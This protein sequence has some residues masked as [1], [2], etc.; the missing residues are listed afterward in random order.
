MRCAACISPVVVML[1]LVA[2]SVHSQAPK[3]TVVFSREHIRIAV[4]PDGIRVDASYVFTNRSAVPQRQ[5]LF[6]PFPIDSLHPYPDAVAVRSDGKEVE[7][8][9]Q[10]DGVVITID[11]P[12]RGQSVLTVAYQQASRQA[13]RRARGDRS[14]CYILTTTS[15]WKSPLQVARFEITVP[16]SLELTD[17]SYPVDQVTTADGAHVHVIDREEFLPDRDL[18][19]AWRPAPPPQR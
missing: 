7:S 17:V 11:V 12:P 4:D 13:S 15:A 2:G 19:F 3:A 14:G 6:Y 18:C 16:D 5:A 10:G 8:R 1:V 9:R